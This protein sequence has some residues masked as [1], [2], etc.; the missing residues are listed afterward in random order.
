M[1][2]HHH[3]HHEIKHKTP[4]ECGEGARGSR[5]K[6]GRMRTRKTCCL[7]DF[8]LGSSSRALRNSRARM[9]P[10]SK[11][12]KK[13][14]AT[15][16]HTQYSIYSEKREG[17]E[18]FWKRDDS[19]RTENRSVLILVLSVLSTKYYVLMYYDNLYLYTS[20]EA[21]CG[22]RGGVRIDWVCL[23]AHCP[24]PGGLRRGV[25]PLCPSSCACCEKRPCDSY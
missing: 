20:C 13:V 12:K 10:N 1:W 8:C 18:A 22:Q 3:D 9:Q 17:R 23:S 25:S 6:E 24:P 14:A 11:S 16:T 5:R 15:L 2:Y 4:A 19:G 21:A 7:L